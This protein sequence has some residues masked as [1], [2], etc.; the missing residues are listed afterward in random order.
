MTSS[1]ILFYLCVAFVVG[2]FLESV[3]ETPQNILWG[4][5][6]L[7][8]VGVFAG[9]KNPIIAI[10][11]FCVLFLVL[12]ILRMQISEF[13]IM[14]DKLSKLNDK[15]EI[16]LTG[17]VNDEPDLKD[18]SQTLKVKVENCNN[19]ILVTASRYP[20][21]KYLD[22]L[23]IT[24]KLETP[25][26]TEEFSYKNYLLK[27]YIYSVIYFPKIEKLGKPQGSTFSFV[28]SGILW[29]KDKMRNSIRNNFLPPQS[30][31][32]EGVILGDKHVISQDIKDK[33]RNTGL[34]H[35][36]AVSGLHIVI[37]SSIVMY[38]LLMLGLWRNQAFYGAIIFI[39]IYVA[40]VGFPA[41]AVRAGIMGIIYLLAQKL[42]RQTT[43]TRII[44]LV[45]ALMLLFNPLLL[46]YDVGFQLSFLAVLGI[47]LLDPII[48]SLVKIPSKY[49]N[50]L[51]LFT[52]TI[53]AQ[54]FTLPL[55]IYNFGNIS[56]VSIFTNILI[57]PVIP[58]IML[59]GF[60]SSIAGIIW[61]S[62]GWV[63]SLPCYFLLSY[64]FWVVDVFSK[65]WAYKVIENVSWTWLAVFYI[66]LAVFLRYFNK[67]LYTRF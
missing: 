62:L 21:Y 27:D 64:V 16:I 17:V 28:Y 43:S 54:I 24:G 48:K 60:L 31:L 61:A 39:L 29:I 56:F 65:P 55:I 37:L 9:V 36:I 23:K 63:I 7:G 50:T 22:R 18:N 34:S 59:F 32:L 4:F 20:E 5:L 44:V 19:T 52:V 11:G 14:N 53:S 8:V 15:E 51:S 41:S 47:I 40:L 30:S 1:K 26:E 33:F 67:K 57:L 35:I 13:N 12:G 25:M 2:I 6:F 42:G 46:F 3:F 10:F 66:P 49:Q 45:A 58:A 38:I